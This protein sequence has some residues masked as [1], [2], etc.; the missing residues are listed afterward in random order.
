MSSTT[1]STSVNTFVPKQ[2]PDGTSKLTFVALETLNKKDGRGK[3][4]K[5]CFLAESAV[6][7]QEPKTVGF[8]AALNFEPGNSLDTAIKLL[9]GKLEIQ[10]TTDEDGCLMM[11][12]ITEEDLEAETMKFEGCIYWAVLE[13]EKGKSFWNVNSETLK[14]A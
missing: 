14:A 12:S 7:G 4:R 11:S 9:G 10:T 5:F 8:T 3:F 13:K 1:K 2:R 6:I